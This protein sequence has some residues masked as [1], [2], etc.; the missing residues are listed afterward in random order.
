MKKSRFIMVALGT[1]AVGTLGFGYWTSVL[2]E[3]RYRALLAQAETNPA[4]QLKADAFSRG[5]PRSTAV[6]EAIVKPALLPVAELE[7]AFA[8]TIYHGLLP[9][10]C[11]VSGAQQPTAPVTVHTTLAPSPGLAADLIALYPPDQPPLSLWLC[12]GLDG[13]MDAELILAPLTLTDFGSLRRLAFAGLT[14]QVQQNAARVIE[15]AELTLAETEVQT[16]DGAL[17][18]QGA[19]RVQQF[20]PARPSLSALQHAELL[21]DTRGEL[22]PATLTALFTEQLRQAA[23]A[24]P[25][26]S[27]Q[28][29]RQAASKAT[30]L[31]NLLAS[32]RFLD[33]T[34]QGYRLHLL[35]ADGEFRLNGS[36][37]NPRLVFMTLA[38][39]IRPLLS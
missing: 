38:V 6:T 36:P 7:L 27:A 3:Q 20:N 13:V 5:W 33:R 24:T 1:L 34:E 15:R 39:L 35:Y 2:A 16:A 31:L 4:L 17:Q 29:S 37:R 22:L 26:D 11:P 8:H 23:T 12:S 10:D 25:P 28:L 21:L 14:G 18:M 30:Q 19:L 9:V 32:S